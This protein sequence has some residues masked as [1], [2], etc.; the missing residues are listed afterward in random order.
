MSEL[1]ELIDHEGIGQ[2]LNDM[3]WFVLTTEADAPPLLTSDKPLF[4]SEKLGAPG[5]HLTLPI[6]PN[7][8]F[9]AVNSK[10]AEAEFR[11]RPQKELIES[12]NVRSTQQ[13]AK[14]VYGSDNAQSEFVDRYISSAR[15]PPFFE[16]VRNLRKQKHASR[17][18]APG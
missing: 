7:R 10:D 14:Y 17:T 9:V 11:A 16:N 6:A 2:M 3:H 12:T 5:C 13:A 18:E 4:I 1:P 8:L 15:H